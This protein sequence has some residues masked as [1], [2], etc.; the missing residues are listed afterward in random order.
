VAK[1]TYEGHKCQVEGMQYILL[2][3]VYFGE[4]GI[5]SWEVFSFSLGQKGS[6]NLG[7]YYCYPIC[8]EKLVRG[9]V[10]TITIVFFVEEAGFNTHE[11][12]I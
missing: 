3:L 12:F 11:H 1:D 6:D 2:A 9:F 5:Y 7:K 4:G 10:F 8:R